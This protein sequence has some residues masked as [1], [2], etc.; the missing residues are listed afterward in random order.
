[1][2]WLFTMH[3]RLRSV[4]SVS[5]AAAELAGRA[6]PSCVDAAGAGISVIDVCAVIA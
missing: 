5:E 2:K 6:L 3:T 4:T 1:M